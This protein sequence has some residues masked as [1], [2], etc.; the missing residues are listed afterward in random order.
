MKFDCSANLEQFRNSG[1][2]IKIERCGFPWRKTTKDLPLR[3]TPIAK[4][5]GPVTVADWGK[6][7]SLLCLCFCL[8]Q[9]FIPHRV[10][11]RR[12]RRRRTPRS[13]RTS[14]GPIPVVRLV[15]MA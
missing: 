5:L 10:N 9:G 6:S 13:S 14:R 3:A 7:C 15:T 1:G 12:A 4:L 11:R 2:L 8:L